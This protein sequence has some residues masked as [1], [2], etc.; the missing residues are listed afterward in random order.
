MV[1]QI[2]ETKSATNAQKCFAELICLRNFP[3]GV[4]IVRK[5]SKKFQTLKWKKFHLHKQNQYRIFVWLAEWVDKTN[6]NAFGF[7][8]LLP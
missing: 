5:K 1:V 3:D 4:Q 6:K 2:T 7:C 8:L